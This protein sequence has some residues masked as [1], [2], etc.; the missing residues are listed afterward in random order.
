MDA[1][2]YVIDCWFAKDKY[3][4]NLAKDL[5]EFGYKV[6]FT[7]DEPWKLYVDLPNS[8]ADALKMQSAAFR[9]CRVDHI[10]CLV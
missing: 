5:M 7:E 9:R 4:D 2:L 3:I 8:D 6:S 10:E 1:R